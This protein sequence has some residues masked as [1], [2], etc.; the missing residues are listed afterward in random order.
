MDVPK[1]RQRRDAFAELASPD[2]IHDPYPFMRWL[3]EQDPVHRAESGLFLLSRHAD[4]NWA[5]KATGDAFRGPTA[6]ELARYF[7]RAATSLRS[8]C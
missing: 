2:C 1:P 6:G 5:V 7:P 8:S 4:I 3:R